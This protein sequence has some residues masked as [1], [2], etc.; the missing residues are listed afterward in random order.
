MT[1]VKKLGAAT[2]LTLIM[3]GG[4]VADSHSPTITIATVNNGDMIRMQG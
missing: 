4:A 2:A 3:S 1:L